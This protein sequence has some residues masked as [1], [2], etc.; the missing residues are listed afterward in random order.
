MDPM[1]LQEWSFGYERELAPRIGGF[2]RYIHKQVDVAIED[3]GA[4]DAT[5][6]EI[7]VIGN[8]GFNNAA[9]FIDRRHRRS[10]DVSR[11]PCVTTTR[12][13]SASTSG[14]RT[15]GA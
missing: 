8:P 12:W 5:G 6:N 9:T 1:K 14:S 7:Y 10:E 13:K 2:A 3:I 11:R 4:L 15:T